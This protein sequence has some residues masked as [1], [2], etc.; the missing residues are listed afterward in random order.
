M[1]GSAGNCRSSVG[2]ADSCDD[3]RRLF[4][5]F[6]KPPWPRKVRWEAVEGSAEKCAQCPGVQT[7]SRTL[8]ADWKLLASPQKP[9]VAQQVPV[10]RKTQRLWR[11]FGSLSVK[12]AVC[13]GRSC[14]VRA[15]R[16]D[17]W[18]RFFYFRAPL[19]ATPGEAELVIALYF[20]V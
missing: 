10:C 16:E 17:F 6:P 1:G 19:E 5:D 18:L 20:K 3:P 2:F 11:C 7:C 12:P 14:R 15:W 8:A 4:H 13:E 9:R